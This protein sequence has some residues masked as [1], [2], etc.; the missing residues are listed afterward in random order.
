MELED[1][2]PQR[3]SRIQRFINDT[4][5]ETLVTIRNEIK[6]IGSRLQIQNRESLKYKEELQKRYDSAIEQIEEC[7]HVLQS[8]TAVQVFDETANIAKL[9]REN[10][11]PDTKMGECKQ[12]ARND[13]KA[14]YEA[15]KNNAGIPNNPSDIVLRKKCVSSRKSVHDLLPA[16]A[17]PQVQK[18]STSGNFHGANSLTKIL[19]SESNLTEERFLDHMQ[20]VDTEVLSNKRS[21]RNAIYIP[22][23]NPQLN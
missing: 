18:D 13:T 3:K 16:N 11:T 20:M 9:E 22:P 12:N 17:P 6:S 8:G 14:Q 2:L 15:F 19:P 21:R 10:R 4:E 23:S 7:K 5:R 1:I